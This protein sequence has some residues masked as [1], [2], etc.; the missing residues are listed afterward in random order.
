MTARTL[1]ASTALAAL[2]AS[3]AFALL[4]VEKDEL[5]RPGFT[6]G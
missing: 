2:L 1:L 5:N 4:D 3:P 6:G